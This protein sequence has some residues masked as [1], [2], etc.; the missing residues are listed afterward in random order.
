MIEGVKCWPEEMTS[1]LERFSY[2]NRTHDIFKTDEKSIYDFF[3]S[4]LSKNPDKILLIDELGKEYSYEEINKLINQ[5]SAYLINE[6]GIKVQDKI[7]VM[8]YNSVEFVVAFLS[9][10]KV[11][12]TMIPIPTKFKKLEVDSYGNMIRFDKIIVEEDLKDY[13]DSKNLIISVNDGYGF[14][15]YIENSK[16]V[17]YPEIKR[18]YTSAI[19]FTSGTT[20]QSKGC[21]IRNYNM[22]HAVK[23]YEYVLDISDNDIAAIGTPFCYVTGLVAVLGLFIEV[24]ATV[25][26]QKFF[27]AS[28][29]LDLVKKYD[30]NFVHASPTVFMKLLECK[31]KYQEVDSL[32]MFVCGASK[33][34]VA[35]INEIKEW[36]PKVEFFTV[37]GL[38]ETTSPGTIV[39]SEVYGSYFQGSSGLPIPGMNVKVLDINT[40]EELSHNEVGEV[41]LTGTNVIDNYYNVTGKIDDEGWLKTGDLGYYNEKGFLYIVDRIKDMINVGG[42]KVWSLEIEELIFKIP[43]VEEV[44]VVGVEDPLYGEQVA[45]VIRLKSDSLLT[46]EDISTLLAKEVAKYKIPK[47]IEFVEEIPKN[48]NQKVDKNKIK[49]FLEVK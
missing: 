34:P 7:A 15:K 3:V 6:A 25:V 44:A 20:S 33:M 2:K 5:F 39:P 11:G 29:L 28:K 32:D 4:S 48:K 45:S 35:K 18:D 21:E 26:F 40:G 31:D 9:I 49:E 16:G 17:T 1:K 42:E 43:G 24:G 8:L 10:L 30:A 46:K 14:E 19:M 13:F 36:L 23:A 22:T 38:T 47:I 12:A 37:Y 27:N 41:L